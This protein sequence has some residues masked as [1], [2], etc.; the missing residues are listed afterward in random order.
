MN[1]KKDLIEE[2]TEEGFQ[3]K[4]DLTTEMAIAVLLLNVVTNLHMKTWMHLHFILSIH[5]M[6]MIQN[7]TDG[8]QVWL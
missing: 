3:I 4:D 8:K 2:L 5:W 1:T 6:S 7:M